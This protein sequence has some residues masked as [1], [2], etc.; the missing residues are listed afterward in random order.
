MTTVFKQ[1]DVE[2][3]KSIKKELKNALEPMVPY[4]IDPL[5]FCR[6]AHEVKDKHIKN[7]LDMLGLSDKYA[8][9]QKG[10]PFYGLDTKFLFNLDKDSWWL[11]DTYDEASSVADGLGFIDSIEIVNV[12]E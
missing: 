12:N 7:V 5:E 3:L 9:L 11:Y 4:R 1:I 6:S 2:V 8:I 10:N